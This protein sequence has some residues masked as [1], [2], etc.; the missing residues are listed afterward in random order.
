MFGWFRTR[1][2]NK[3]QGD[4]GESEAPEAPERRHMR[5]MF[6]Y[7]AANQETHEAAKIKRLEFDC[8]KAQAL[9]YAQP[10][11]AQQINSINLLVPKYDDYEFQDEYDD[12][13]TEFYEEF[14]E[15]SLEVASLRDRAWEGYCQVMAERLARYIPVLN[16]KW[17][18]L[19]YKDEF[20]D[21][22]FDRYYQFFKEFCANKMPGYD[23]KI[24]N[25]IV[26]GIGFEEYEKLNLAIGGAE[27]R[28]GMS[29]KDY[30]RLCA[31]RFEQWGWS[32][33]L[34]PETGDQ[35]ADIIIKASSGSTAVQ[36]KLYSQPVG[37][38]A[39]QEVI[40][41]RQFYKTSAGVVVTNAEFTK[42][43]R[44]LANA[45]GVDLL[46]HDQISSWC[47]ERGMAFVGQQHG[48]G[49]QTEFDVSSFAEAIIVDLASIGLPRYDDVA[50]ATSVWAGEDGGDDLY[51]R[52]VRVVASERVASPAYLQ[53]YLRIG[54][55]A[56]SSLIDRMERECVVS[57]PNVAGK[58]EVLVRKS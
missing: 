15:K 9:K 36:C 13:I 47:S 24:I 43:A 5:A 12:A 3:T 50:G 4:G 29:P 1:A 27:F 42:S 51:S 39:V 45:S 35:G 32:A 41:A 11:I 38:G 31:S 19:V 30:E 23:F 16:V 26:H 22:V 33:M 10:D 52:A 7:T 48:V 8:L 28:D 18:Q 46:H 6:R 25:K 58:R 34:T 54:Y 53:R 14:R 49:T 55:N 17:G 20:G 44:Q 37:N 40:A 56:A 2:D 21:T 57:K